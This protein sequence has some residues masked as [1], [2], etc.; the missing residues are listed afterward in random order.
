MLRLLTAC[1]ILTG[2]TS[3]CMQHFRLSTLISVVSEWSDESGRTYPVPHLMPQQHPT[4]PVMVREILGETPEKMLPPE[5][6]CVQLPNPPVVRNP[7][8]FT[9]RIVVTQAFRTLL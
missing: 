2:L 1:C 8:D 6:D 4:Q 3:V 7:R 9:Q 5:L